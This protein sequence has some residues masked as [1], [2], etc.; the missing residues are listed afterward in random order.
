MTFYA[1][2]V[3]I[4]PDG[5]EVNVH[6]KDRGPG[7]K[8][9]L[10]QKTLRPD[11]TVIM[12]EVRR[13][14]GKQRSR[15]QHGSVTP[16][17]AAQPPKVVFD[18]TG[19]RVINETIE[20]DGTAVVFLRK[21]ILKMPDGSQILTA[22][23]NSSPNA[24]VIT[25]EKRTEPSGYVVINEIRS[26]AQKIA[27]RRRPF[28]THNIIEDYDMPLSSPHENDNYNPPFNSTGY[29]IVNQTRL[30]DGSM[31][32]I[33]RKSIRKGPDGRQILAEDT[34]RSPGVTV[35]TT[36]LRNRPDG[37]V[38]VTEFHRKVP[39]PLA[40]QP[41]SPPEDSLDLSDYK[42]VNTTKEPNGTTVQVYQ[43]TVRKLPNG[44]EIVTD[45]SDPAA[46]LVTVEKHIHPHGKVLIREMRR[47]LR[48]KSRDQSPLSLKVIDY[49]YDIPALATTESPL[50]TTNTEVP[51]N[52]TGF[53]VISDRRDAEGTWIVVFRKTIK[54]LDDGTETLTDENDQSPGVTTVTVERRTNKDGAQTFKEIRSEPKGASSTPKPAPAPAVQKALK[55]YPGFSIEKSTSRKDGSF[56]LIVRSTKVSKTKKVTR[57]R[58]RI[59]KSGKIEKEEELGDDPYFTLAQR[60]QQE[61]DEQVQQPVP[62][63]DHKTKP[64]N[65]D[66]SH[67][68][69]RLGYL[70]E[71][72]HDTSYRLVT[73][74]VEKDGTHLYVYRKK[75]RHNKY[76]SEV[77]VDDADESRGIVYKVV[78][79]RR[80]PDGKIT[81]A[82]RYEDFRAPTHPAHGK[83]TAT[84]APEI[85]QNSPSPR[86]AHNHPSGAK[87]SSK[88]SK[89]RA[90]ASSLPT[91]APNNH[92]GDPM[93]RSRVQALHNRPAFQ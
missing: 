69:Y 71:V 87:K 48:S 9:I 84:A 63:A 83:G 1:K 61:K 52:Y 64:A 4:Q 56:I 53:K 67:S 74:R 62:Q 33:Y 24:V 46:V 55:H 59:S 66:S 23:D 21:T 12:K 85:Q 65:P 72:E 42:I 5:A 7:R 78:E 40:A 31:V 8:V 50:T 38:D 19:Y 25:V 41:P 15:Q 58:L 22:D 35:L 27:D 44:A 6:E 36:E 29:K 57:K 60:E 73:N 28:V 51:F 68:H 3:K 30:P 17:E 45:D 91:P 86:V 43:K 26:P 16:A 80:M 88:P 76:G 70:H 92:E 81:Y 47:A 37:T 93:W 79:K 14:N 82:Q 2:T 89:H 10:L 77:S 75:I 54:K 18:S 13:N 34:D 11:G 39:S 32:T 20:K 90:P 49:D